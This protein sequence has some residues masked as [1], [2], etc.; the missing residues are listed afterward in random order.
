MEI[1]LSEFRNSSV[2]E[3]I[4]KCLALSESSNEHEAAA[5]M[6]QARKLMEKHGLS[7]EAMNIFK[8]KEESM[9]T[10]YSN[11]PAWFL[12]LGQVIAKAF[13][14]S[15]Y[16]THKKFI[17]V[18]KDAC[19]EVARYSFDVLHR[20]LVFQKNKFL[21]SEKVIFAAAAVKRKIGQAYCEG[22]ICGVGAIVD[23]F[24][25]R[26]TD[27]ESNEHRKYLQTATQKEIGEKDSSPRKRKDDPIKNW[28]AAH[29]WESGKKVKLHEGVAAGEQPLRIS[30]DN[31]ESKAA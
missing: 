18:G 2:M 28:A 21:N 4:R 1:I 20:Q 14:C 7:S 11:P 13:Q 9:E 24:A 5:A 29:G 6:R 12:M 22:W 25:S 23:E 19:A 17:F 16:T 3:K 26:L 30:N 27:E 10:K 8:I 15:I 31:H